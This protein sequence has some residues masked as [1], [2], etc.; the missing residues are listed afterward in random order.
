MTR[1][2]LPAS[3][4]VPR[5]NVK[6]SG[7][8]DIFLLEALEALLFLVVILRIYMI[9]LKIQSTFDLCNT[10]IHTIRTFHRN[11]KTTTYMRGIAALS[12]AKNKL[13]TIYPLKTSWVATLTPKKIKDDGFENKEQ[14][15][16]EEIDPIVTFS[17]PPPVPPVLGPLVLLS[18]WETWSTPDEK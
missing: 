13:N 10:S 15:K 2:P 1:T 8:N 17:K 7:R 16:K 18:L 11:K 6:K 5:S 12:Q 14:M 3:I 4:P 9:I